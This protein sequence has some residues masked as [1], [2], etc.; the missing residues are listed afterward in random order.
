MFS[1]SDFIDQVK[2]EGFP[3]SIHVL[4]SSSKSAENIP[5]FV[6][7]RTESSQEFWLVADQILPKLECKL[8]CIIKC[9]KSQVE[10]DNKMCCCVHY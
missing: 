2:N 10:N 6:W 4:F 1:K 5:C 3:S 8:Y 7:P 9:Y